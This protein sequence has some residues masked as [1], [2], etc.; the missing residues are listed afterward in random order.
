MSGSRRRI[1]ARGLACPEPVILTKKAL[2]EDGSAILEVLVDNEAARDNVARFAAFSGRTLSSIVES[3]GSY[4][5][6]IEA[7]PAASGQ[8]SGGVSPAVGPAAPGLAA[9]VKGTAGVTVLIP[10]DKL[11]RGDEELGALLLKGFIYA[12]AEADIPPKRIIFMNSGVRACVEDSVSLDDLRRLEAKGVV[13]L[14]C[15]TCL[16]FYNIKNRLA[17]GRISNMYE[18]SACLLD[19]ATISI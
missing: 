18:I 16:D 9:S 19:G 15:G 2:E 8:E 11:G 6:T 12:L 17:V 10:S 14:S 1:D 3:S 5:L 13:V 7:G 4:T